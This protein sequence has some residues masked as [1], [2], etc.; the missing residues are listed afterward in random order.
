[1]ERKHDEQC[2][3]DEQRERDDQMKDLT[4]LLQRFHPKETHLTAAMQCIL[5]KLCLSQRERS[6]VMNMEQRSQAWLNARSRRLTGSV[7]SSAAGNGYRNPK[8]QSVVKEMLWRQFKGNAYTEYGTRNEPNAEASYQTFVKKKWHPDAAF[9]NPGLVISK[10]YPFLGASPDGIGRI[11][12]DGQ[13]VLYGIEY[14]CPFKG[15]LYP[16][17]PTY[18][19]D[20]LVGVCALCQVPFIDFVVWT[21]TETSIITLP[22]SRG[23]LA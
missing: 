3:A 7:F 1:M 21:P 10:Q 13:T 17:T 19:Y 14:K 11:T 2:E 5:R 9:S 15:Q 8:P 4:V 20:Q 22:L 18:Y 12:V 6:A 23:L 16:R